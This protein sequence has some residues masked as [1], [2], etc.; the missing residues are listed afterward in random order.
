[1]EPTLE[2]GDRILVCRICLHVGDIHRGDV[3]VFSD[4]HPGPGV[5]RGPVG[6]AAALARAGARRRA[7]RERG[8]HQAG[9]RASRAT[10]SSSTTGQL[11]VNGEKVDEP[12]LNPEV[13]T[14]PF[15]PMTV[16]DGMLFVL[17]D[18]RAHSGDSRFPPPTGLGLRPG[19]HGDREGVRDRV[20]AV[21]VGMAV[22]AGT[23]TATRRALRAQGF[24]PDRRRRRGRPRRARGPARRGGRGDPAEGFDTT[25]IRDS[26]LLTAKQREAAFE[27]IVAGVRVRRREGRAAGARQPGAAPVEH[28]AA[29]PGRPG[30][31]PEPDYALTDGFPVPRMPCP[32]AR[33]S[34]RATRWRRAWRPR[35]SSRR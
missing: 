35:R 25:G 34:R 31:R 11:F 15:G 30:A 16:P 32:V 3:I 14:R 29:A 17:G 6:A 28:R 24:S 12:Y 27:R 4:P 22:D 20:S 8:L 33:R 10:S 23:S 19:G 21:E 18:N 2:K 26:K 5:D 1:M 7:A 13:D 9:D